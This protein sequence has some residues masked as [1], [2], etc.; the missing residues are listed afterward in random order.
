MGSRSFRSPS[1]VIA[2]LMH[3]RSWNLAAAFSWTRDAHPATAITPSVSLAYPPPLP[4]LSFPAPTSM[5]T[6]HIAHMHEAAQARAQ[7]QVRG[8]D[9]LTPALHVRCVACCVMWTGC[10]RP[11]DVAGCNH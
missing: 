6:T 7:V 10:A 4:L 5:Q 8:N 1:V 11:A 9:T 2:Y 3:A